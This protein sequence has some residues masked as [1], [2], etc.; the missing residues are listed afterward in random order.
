MILTI[1]SQLDFILDENGYIA[2]N[3]Y[4][5]IDESDNELI[6]SDEENSFIIG[7]GDIVG[8]KG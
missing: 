8:F 5:L 7:N 1:N 6:I 3:E 4:F 2:S